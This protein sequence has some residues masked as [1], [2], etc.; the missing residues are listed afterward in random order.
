[1]MYLKT[2]YIDPNTQEP[3]LDNR[4][5]PNGKMHPAVPTLDVKFQF[6]DDNNATFTVAV[7]D[8]DVDVSGFTGVEVM[9]YATTATLLEE[10]FNQERQQKHLQLFELVKEMKSEVIDKWWHHSEIS[11]SMNIKISEARLA[12]DAASE[13]DARTVAPFVTQEADARQMTVKELSQ[14]IINNYDGLIGAEAIITGHRGLKSDEMD[15]IP[16]VSD[17]MSTMESSF[18]NLRNY[19]YTEGF[20]AIRS[21]LGI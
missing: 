4:Q 1:M 18:S 20:D 19:D 3:F 12:M 14:R 15:A 16:F 11:A 2:Y 8:P 6:L 21:Q 17:S 7:V 5:A 13:N 10:E 9:T